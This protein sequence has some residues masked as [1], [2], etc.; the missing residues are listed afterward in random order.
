[1]LLAASALLIRCGLAESVAVPICCRLLLLRSNLAAVPI[2]MVP[3]LLYAG[4]LHITTHEMTAS[5]HV[6]KIS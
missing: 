3:L 5:H 2:S 1:M 6:L 4:L